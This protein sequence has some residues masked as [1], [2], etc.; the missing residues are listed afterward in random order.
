[1]ILGT[2]YMLCIMQT[3]RIKT[4]PVGQ[5]GRVAVYLMKLQEH[6]ALKKI[7][8]KY[9]LRLYSLARA[10]NCKKN[11]FKTQILIYRPCFD[12]THFQVPS[13]NEAYYA[14]HV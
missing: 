6:L 12:A 10:Q 9:F 4:R 8:F 7:H 14:Q 1:M 11:R 5:P 2:K 3:S 13:A